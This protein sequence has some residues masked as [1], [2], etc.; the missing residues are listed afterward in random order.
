MDDIKKLSNDDPDDDGDEDLEKLIERIPDEEY[1][2][3]LYSS[4]YNEEFLKL[5]D[6]A[7]EK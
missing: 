6:K 2:K 3:R 5:V 4:Q 1:E 7:R